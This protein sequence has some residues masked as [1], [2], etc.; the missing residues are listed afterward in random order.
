MRSTK[1]LLSRG[2]HHLRFAPNAVTPDLTI[3]VAGVSFA[4]SR[5][6]SLDATTA[7]AIAGGDAYRVDLTA[8]TAT[9][10][11]ADSTGLIQP[12]LTRGHDGVLW[13]AVWAAHEETNPA[14]VHARPFRRV[15]HLR[16]G[17]ADLRSRR[18]P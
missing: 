16:R 7:V 2:R 6:R 17:S 15:E 8:G 12:N 13:A 1:S 14:P 10:I 11:P 5:L 18:S 3:T 4:Q 9:L